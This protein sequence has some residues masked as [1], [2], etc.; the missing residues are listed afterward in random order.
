M[1]TY[2]DLNTKNVLVSGASGDIGLA[3]CEKYL[4]QGCNVYA[5]F[6]INAEPLRLLSESHD[7]GH[8]LTILQCD[9]ANPTSVSDLVIHLGCAIERLDVLV[10]NAG[11]VKDNLFS[12]M[13]FEDFNTVIETNV[14]STFHL[15]KEV[16][17]LLRSAEGAT[18][19][20][21]ASIAGIIPSVGQANY[22]ASKG[23]LL[24]FTRTLAA[25]LAPRGIR[26][27]A[28][29]PGMIASKM[30]K[31][32]SRTVV[33]D[34]TNSIPLKR[35]GDCNEVANT[36]VWLSSSASSYIVGQTIVI[37]GGLVMR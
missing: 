9:L 18:I 36:I 30:V 23:A 15:T 7:N 8:R 35:L 24:G 21:V 12:S 33:R 31:K 37:D 34:V 29:A 14:L 32:V 28:V 3:I 13:S 26:V 20:N 6:K 5:I 1:Y 10:N 11:I 22:S 4:D 27:N 16:L 17:K 2:K 19:I 25:E